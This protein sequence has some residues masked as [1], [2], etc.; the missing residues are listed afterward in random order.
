MLLVVIKIELLVISLQLLGVETHLRAIKIW[1]KVTITLSK[2][3]R[4]LFKEAE[5]A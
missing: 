2:E 3:A 1:R 4:I 5:T